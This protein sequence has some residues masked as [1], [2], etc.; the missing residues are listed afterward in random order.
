MM[1][2]DGRGRSREK[3]VSTRKRQVVES[4][5]AAKRENGEGTGIGN[6]K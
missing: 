3:G 6:E 4:S 5:G 2:R 1:E